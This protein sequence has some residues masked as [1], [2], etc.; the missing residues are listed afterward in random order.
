MKKLLIAV[1]FIVITSS[2]FAS[3]TKE[4]HEWMDTAKSYSEDSLLYS[5]IL[6]HLR[7]QSLAEE[8]SREISKIE[9]ALKQNTNRNIEKINEFL[10]KHNEQ[11][12]LDDDLLMRLALIYYQQSNFKL[13]DEMEVYHQRLSL[14][15]AK[16]MQKSPELPQPN[17]GS[18][19]DYCKRL[20]LEYPNS[21]FADYARYLLGVIQEEVGNYD[22]AKKYYSDIIRLHPFSKHREEVLWRHAELSFDFGEYDSSSTG[23]EELVKVNSQAY[24]QR[25]LYKLGALEF[26]MKKYESSMLRFQVLLSDETEFE[27]LSNSLQKE[28]YEYIGLLYLKGQSLK[29]FNDTQKFRAVSAVG[30]RME[31]HNQYLYAREIFQKFIKENPWNTKIPLYYS[32]VVESLQAEGKEEE[33]IVWQTRLSKHLVNNGTWWRKNTDP[34]SRMIAEEN[35]EKAK[36]SVA[37][38]YANLALKTGKKTDY[39]KAA[40]E[41]ENFVKTESYSSEI[42][43]AYFE[44]GQL[45]MELKKYSLAY[46][47]FQNSLSLDLDDY[48]DLMISEMLFAYQ[49]FLNLNK[50]KFGIEV[51]TEKPLAL[52][53]KEKDFLKKYHQY[54]KELVDTEY[55]LPLDSLVANIYLS[56]ANLIEAT[57]TLEMMLENTYVDSKQIQYIE[58]AGKWL[59]EIYS[60][61]K[62]WDLAEKVSQK[63]NNLGAK[64]AANSRKIAKLRFNNS[65]LLEAEVF[66][67]QGNLVQAAASFLSFAASNPNDSEAIKSKLKAAQLYRDSYNYEKSNAILSK[68]FNSDY[69]S[70]VNQIYAQNLMD[71]FQFESLK[72]F[73]KNL[74]KSDYRANSDLANFD[75]M[76]KF[77]KPAPSFGDRFYLSFQKNKDLSFGLQAFKEYYYSKEEDKAQKVLSSIEKY[78]SKNSRLELY[79][80]RALFNYS[81]GDLKVAK[82][83]CQSYQAE[84]KKLKKIEFRRQELHYQCNWILNPNF[85]LAM[86]EYLDKAI[87]QKAFE[88]VLFIAMDAKRSE[89][90]IMKTFLAA[91]ELKEMQ[92]SPIFTA[93]TNY[94][95]GLGA[96]KAASFELFPYQIFKADTIPWRK[97]DGKGQSFDVQDYCS[98]VGYG[99]CYRKLL[100]FQKK[101]NSQ[102]YDLLAKLAL[103]VDKSED[104]KEWISEWKKLN[105]EIEKL[106]YRL[107]LNNKKPNEKDHRV[108]IY[109]G[110]AYAFDYFQLAKYFFET[111]QE[112]K[113]NFVLDKVRKR[114]PNS[115][116]VQAST[117]LLIGRG[118]IFLSGEVNDPRLAFLLKIQGSL[119]IDNKQRE[120]EVFAFTDW[121]DNA[122]LYKNLFNKKANPRIRKKGNSYYNLLGFY[123]NYSRNR[124]EESKENLEKIGKTGVFYPVPEEWVD[125]KRGVASE[126]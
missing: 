121:N 40:R 86:S 33:A 45:Y 36:I 3:A 111:D 79:G 63:L 69:R 99:R 70:S 76:L 124:I 56:K 7:D 114:Y 125:A 119:N 95:K 9:K 53:E 84:Y 94:L 123:Y 98:K 92:A 115:N 30:E 72:K 103:I 54:R 83:N 28:V 62:K 117:K 46:K 60:T 27:S 66:E 6:M 113:A 85:K 19:E 58:D 65:I 25:A 12:V 90:E 68:L 87:E 78:N 37:R 29:R 16:K 41:Y 2:S 32:K 88:S 116:L 49:K 39:A 1:S 15:Y 75:K 44:L 21:T 43:L 17:Y 11:I 105:P 106:A 102:D 110:K 24:K 71:S 101:N 100:G 8:F 57:E 34:T 73:L 18:T 26:Q 52:N 89:K 38:Y 93:V 109:N 31:R 23:Y 35:I 13:Q 51:L 50:N 67:Q 64:E 126:K 48:R 107:A 112:R 47:A 81:F 80:I 59:T 96:Y 108:A 5:K 20:L 42:A 82:D 97:L 91:R 4:F 118:E 122:L 10:V 104:A 74:K 120:R 14:Y 77:F 61:Q 22:Q 55:L